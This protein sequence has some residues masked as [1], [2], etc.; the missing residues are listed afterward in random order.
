MCFS[1]V[2]T[3]GNYLG[4]SKEV[5]PQKTLHSS[6]QTRQQ[7]KTSESHWAYCVFLKWAQSLI[8]CVCV[9]IWCFILHALLWTHHSTIRFVLRGN[10]LAHIPKTLIWELK[11]VEISCFSIL[12]HNN[13][14]KAGHTRMLW[15]VRCI[16]F[17]S[18]KMASSSRPA[19]SVS[20][21]PRLWWLV[22]P[23]TRSCSSSCSSP[24]P[25]VT[26]P[27]L[28]LFCVRV[29]VFRRSSLA[30]QPS[31]VTCTLLAALGIAAGQG[32]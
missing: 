17:V 7:T 28:K 21:S 22:S 5:M 25:F 2:W 4:I 19:P 29:S 24:S 27:S 13:F 15:W 23:S 31:G 10:V 26:E 8:S 12:Q 11:N 32:D 30:G 16:D 3:D 20:G 14:S 9:V 1:G 6:K 18:H